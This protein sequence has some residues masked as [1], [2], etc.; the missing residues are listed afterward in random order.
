MRL[1]L[2]KAGCQARLPL[3]CQLNT[4]TACIQQE[5][6]IV[7]NTTHP[8]DLHCDLAATL[9]KLIWT[10]KRYMM[11]HS[12][13]GSLLMLECLQRYRWEN[14]LMHF[15]SATECQSTCRRCVT[16]FDLKLIFL[17]ITV[18][19]MKVN[20]N[21]DTRKVHLEYKNAEL[22]ILN[23]KMRIV[24]IMSAKRPTCGGACFC[25]TPNGAFSH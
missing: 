15:P 5:K 18:T 7:I 1:A 25:Q 20:Y 6:L 23:K 22:R 8:L 14:S 24:C 16:R 19:L 12:T 17:D 9:H 3:C 13:K 10:P 11:R 21:N 2:G 4:V